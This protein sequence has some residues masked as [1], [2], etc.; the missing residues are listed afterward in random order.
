MIPQAWKE[1]KPKIMRR[2]FFFLVV[3]VLGVLQISDVLPTFFGIK[4][5]PLL[6]LTIVLGMFEREVYGLYYGLLAGIMW[7]MNVGAGD[8]FNAFFLALA[9]FVCGLLMTYLM[10]NNLITASLLCTFWSLLY[11]FLIWLIFVAARGVEGS[12]AMLF[13][14]YLPAAVLNILTLPVYYFSVRAVMKKFK[15]MENDELSF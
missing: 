6:P 9:G 13:S 8:G 11:F 1:N 3:L 7:D 14:E 10:M 2:G 15:L 4:Y 12:V 5:L